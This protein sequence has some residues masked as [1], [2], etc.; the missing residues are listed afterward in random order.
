LNSLKLFFLL[1][2]QIWFSVTEGDTVKRQIWKILLRLLFVT[3][4]LSWYPACRILPIFLLATK[5]DPFKKRKRV[6]CCP[7]SIII[8][9]WTWHSFF[10]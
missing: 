8:A 4:P 7:G 9:D 3:R 6:E 2:V 5:T 10:F 1:L